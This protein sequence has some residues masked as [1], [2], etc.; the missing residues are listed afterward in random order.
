MEHYFPRRAKGFESGWLKI[1][2]IC[3]VGMNPETVQGRFNHKIGKERINMLKMIMRTIT[4]QFGTHFERIFLQMMQ[5]AYEQQLATKRITVLEV[6]VSKKLGI[7]NMFFSLIG[8][9][10]QRDLLGEECSDTL[11]NLYTREKVRSLVA[12]D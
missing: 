12:S 5:A 1:F 7:S 9:D 6:D 4:T 3:L 10:F 11:I 2:A 8:L